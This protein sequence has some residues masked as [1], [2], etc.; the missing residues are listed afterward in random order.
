MQSGFR[1]LRGEEFF[2]ENWVTGGM[3]HLLREAFRRF[4]GRSASGVIKLTQAMGGGKTHSMIAL[5]LLARYPELRA[6]VMGG[7]YQEK[8]LVA[9]RVVAFTGRES[10]APL[11]IWGAIAE[12]FGKPAIRDLYA[13][14]RE[15]PGFQQTRGLIRLTRI[16]VS[17]LYDGK[18]C[19][20]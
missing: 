18:P 1:L 7:D 5:G 16:V 19:K 8:D 15:N 4:A 6:E 20:A 10:D 9:V 11:G 12:Q 2:S 17:S 3:R 14:F 13:R